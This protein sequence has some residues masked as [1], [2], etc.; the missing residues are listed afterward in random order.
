MPLCSSLIMAKLMVKMKR[1]I[2]TMVATAMA[3]A[4]INSSVGGTGDNNGGEN[5]S[6]R[7]RM[8]RT[9]MVR[10]YPNVP[11]ATGLQCISQTIVSAYQRMQRR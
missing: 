11:T 7:Q 8:E 2:T 10:T 1:E 9:K 6:V 5:T 4:T 3:A